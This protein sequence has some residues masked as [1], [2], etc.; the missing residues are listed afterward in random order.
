MYQ[1]LELLSSRAN[2]ADVTRAVRFLRGAL[3]Q[4]PSFGDAHYYR[5]LCLAR[6]KQDAGLQKSDLDAASR[7]NSEA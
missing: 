6:L 3:D 5:A 2:T 1:A 4:N 7:Y